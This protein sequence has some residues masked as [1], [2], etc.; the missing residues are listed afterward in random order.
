MATLYDI[1]STPNE[2]TGVTPFLQFFGHPI[3]TKL[4]LLS[5]CLTDAK[6]S[7][8]DVIQEYSKVK[9][10]DKQYTPGALLLFCKGKG[11]SLMH[12]GQI[13]KVLL[14]MHIL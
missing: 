13:V 3:F 12:Q 7:A 5:E 14:I 4:A 2:V 6:G 8:R 1:H 10:I 9:G 11:Q